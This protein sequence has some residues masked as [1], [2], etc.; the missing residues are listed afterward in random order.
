MLQDLVI[1]AKHGNTHI[2]GCLQSLGN[3]YPI[4]VIDTAAGGH[5][6]GAYLKAINQFK[7]KNYF[8]MQDSM[9]ALQKD[10]L[11]PFK[12]ICPDKGAVAW[13]FFDFSYDDTRQREWL[14]AQYSGQHPRLGI[15]GP[16][17]Y[18]SRASLLRLKRLNLLP[19]VPTNK[20]EAQGTERAWA[21]AFTLADI[22][23]VAI[24]MWDKEMMKNGSYPIFRKEFAN[25]Q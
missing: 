9:Y 25:R 21:W 20:L 6:T 19:L 2:D 1:I 3:K 10:Y 4:E 15:F 14:E 24:R 7:A 23:V 16:V 5:P 18:A 12:K 22:P 13:G 17:F 8:F 11:E